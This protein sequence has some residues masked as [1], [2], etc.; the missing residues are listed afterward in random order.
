MQRIE[1]RQMQHLWVLLGGDVVTLVSTGANGNFSN[2]NAGTAKTISTSGFTL[3]GADA[4]N[5][6][7]TQPVL[8]ANITPPFLQ[9]Q[10]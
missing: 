2:K 10:V 8:T 1:Y 4:A 3:G 7:L 9:Y 6:T 5:Y